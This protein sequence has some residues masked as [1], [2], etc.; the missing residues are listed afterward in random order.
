MKKVLT[1][2][3][4]YIM[5]TSVACAQPAGQVVINSADWVDVY[6]SIMYSNFI[7]IPY[8]FAI[9]ETH[10]MDMPVYMDK[11]PDVLLIESQKIPYIT[12][13]KQNLESNGFTI[14][15]EIKSTD[16]SELNVKLAK[17]LDI[18][19]FIIVSDQYG[20]HALSAAPYAIKSR[21]WV[22]FA[23]KENIDSIYEFLTSRNVEKIL[24]FGRVDRIVKDTLSEFDPEK[25]DEGNRFDN[26]LAM[27]RKYMEI[28][29]SDQAILT[30][31]DFI[32]ATLMSGDSPVIFIGGNNVPPQV[33]DYVRSSNI[34]GSIIIGSDLVNAA[35]ILKDNTGISV[36][37]KFGQ[38]RK[39]T[40][41]MSGIEELDK[42]YLP[43]Y[44]LT[45]DVV[46]AQYNEA[47][48]QLEVIYRNDAMIGE[49]FK[50][51]VGIFADGERIGTIGDDEPAYI[52]SE[53]NS[54]RVYDIDLSEYARKGSL[55]AKIFS[56]FGEA[57]GSLNLMLTKDMDIG[58]VSINDNSK[59]E[60]SK[61]EYNTRTQRIELT[62][63][64]TGDVDAYV[65]SSAILRIDGDE[66]TIHIG[67]SV[68]IKAGEKQTIST[69]IEL[70]EADLADNTQIK[71][72][73][74]YGERSDILVNNIDY[75]LPLKVTG[76]ISSI[77]LIGGAVLLI[78][79]AAI[80]VP[81][82]KTGNVKT[83]VTSVKCPKCNET[84]GADV[85][86]CPNC[87]AGVE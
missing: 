62:V 46:S 9:S 66:E 57:T 60:I 65:S 80:V 59:T 77:L 58:T 31:G 11:Q 70:T 3:L 67:N 25:I 34:Q 21:S 19:N 83:A 42:F 14:I 74:T 37:L 28:S 45:L 8:N 48:K 53:S 63:M 61:I 24:I 35:K 47:T 82:R 75:T 15:E 30:N 43:R 32:E 76:G 6:S 23:D 40:G 49:F 38:G 12:N 68:S 33:I 81:R 18:N 51:S 52:E 56:E 54:G 87:G 2:L 7:G 73:V 17:E 16:G 1:I 72:H 64:N 26:N 41:E 55:T 36:F 27:V 44:E 85:K 84:I 39:I 78:L 69:R 13:Y 79:L 50:S 29:P 86:F 71:I 20:Y 5:F 4:L 22:L 10:A